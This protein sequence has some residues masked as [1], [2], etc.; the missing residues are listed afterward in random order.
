MT[1]SFKTAA[2]VLSTSLLLIIEIP[3]F[4]LRGVT[5][6]TL[7]ELMFSCI[8]TFLTALCI[9]EIDRSHHKQAFFGIPFAYLGSVCLI[10]Q[11]IINVVAVFIGGQAEPFAYVFSILAMLGTTSLIISTRVALSHVEGVEA[12]QQEQ[13]SQIGNWRRMLISLCA[14]CEGKE[15]EVISSI[16]SQMRFI[17]PVSTQQTAEIDVSIERELAR[18]SKIVDD[19][20]PVSQN[21]IFDCCDK[22]SRLLACRNH[23]ART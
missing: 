10:I 12:F 1:A 13:T 18:L 22:L 14:L 17:S 9:S 21:D 15:A 20:S 19:S 6:A 4:I 5:R 23:I 11:L 2:I 3:I 7:V 16:E 8:T